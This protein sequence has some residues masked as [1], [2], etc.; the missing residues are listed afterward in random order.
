MAEFKD[1]VPHTGGVLTIRVKDRK[2]QLGYSHMNSKAAG[3][4]ELIAVDGS[5]PGSANSWA[6]RD[7]AVT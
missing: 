3:L 2:Y 6:L 5:H 1:A 7:Q 4:V